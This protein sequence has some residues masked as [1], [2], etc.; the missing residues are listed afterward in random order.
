M[1]SAVVSG[2]GDPDSSEKLA[3]EAKG[4]WPE[5]EHFVD[6]GPWLDVDGKA[7]NHAV[8]T[9][10][11]KAELRKGLR[12]IFIVPSNQEALRAHLVVCSHVSNEV[13]RSIVGEPAGSAGSPPVERK[14]SFKKIERTTSAAAVSGDDVSSSDALEEE[15]DI[16]E[17]ASCDAEELEVTLVGQTVDDSGLENPV[18][19][20]FS[21][22]RSVAVKPLERMSSVNLLP[23]EV[24]VRSEVSAVSAGTEMLVYR[25]NMP[26]DIPTDETIAGESG[27][28]AAKPFEY[29]ALYGYA[30]VGRVVAT[31]RSLSPA[32]KRRRVDIA[33][34]LKV[35]TRVFA[36]REHTSWFVAKVSDLMPVPDGI[37]AQDASFL[38]NV[39]T[40]LSL[41]M[42]A[43]PLPGENV[44]VVGQ[45]IV[46]MLLVT[47]LKLCYGATRVIAID[48]LMDRLEISRSCA[49]ADA[50]VRVDVTAENGSQFEPG[51]RHALPQG[52]KTGVDVSIDVSGTGE[53][54]DTAI[55]ATRDR[56]RVVIGSWFGSKEVAL[57]C[58]GGKFHRSHISLVAS[59]VSSLPVGLSGRWDKS[60][61]F[62]LAWK[63]LPSIKPSS[64]FPVSVKPVTGAASLYEEIDKG[65]HFQVLFTY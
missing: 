20:V 51:L 63:L 62:R 59:Q 46:G 56:G 48:T 36:F 8:R 41:A 14:T 55:R 65:E 35:G 11:C 29:P 64:R 23:G 44:A 32:R 10:I 18:C 31:H 16:V 27:E 49:G 52:D 22:P 30:I 19:V 24:L 6:G 38:P 15:C 2:D 1:S 47:V 34:E 12:Q 13:L 4:R 54:L 21:G 9:A 43:A 42:D 25:G 33:D 28:Q 39:E 53:G 58:L 57:S 60:R 37:N 26:S 3:P 7:T 50:G 5:W 45:G 40:A 17:V 61:R